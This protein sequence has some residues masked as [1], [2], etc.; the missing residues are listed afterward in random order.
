M[1]PD[2]RRASILTIEA[3]GAALEGLGAVTPTALYAQLAPALRY[4]DFAR[5][6][7]SMKTAGLVA[8]TGNGRI[9]W[10]GPRAL[11]RPAG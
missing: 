1:T 3:I 9:L 10:K 11:R 8:E 6:I 5:L 4:K 7:G 2:E